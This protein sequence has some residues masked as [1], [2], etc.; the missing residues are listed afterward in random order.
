MRQVLV[1]RAE[2]FIAHSSDRP[3]RHFL[4]EFV[5]VWIDAGAHRGDEL[6]ELPSLYKVEVGPERPELSRHATG[7]FG[8]MARTAVLI[9]QDVLA[10]S[11]V[12]LAG[13]DVIGPMITGLPV[14]SMPAPSIATPNRLR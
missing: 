8:A 5:A 13:G 11:K 10:I 6:L 12:E 9:R 7:Q 1:D 3:P 14:G 4:A 2:L